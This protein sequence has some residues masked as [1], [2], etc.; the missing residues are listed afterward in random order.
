MSFAGE[1]QGVADLA[2]QVLARLVPAAAG[3]VYIPA[4][5]MPDGVYEGT[6]PYA[7]VR[8]GHMT[9]TELDAGG[10]PLRGNDDGDPNV[11]HV[12]WVDELVSESG[13]TLA[14]TYATLIAFADGIAD[15]FDTGAARHL[16]DAAGNRRADAAGETVTFEFNPNGEAE[17][18]AGQASRLGRSTITVKGLH[19]YPTS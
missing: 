14:A 18:A 16:A 19:R 3:N 11:I 9:V 12:E 17:M 1:L 10:G 7:A 4:P 2:G 8:A 6:Y 13:S 15:L 5:E